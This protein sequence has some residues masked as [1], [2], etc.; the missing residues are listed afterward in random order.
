MKYLLKNHFIITFCLI[1]LVN[2]NVN[3]QTDSLECI[4]TKS[5]LKKLVTS[6]NRFEN[7]MNGT[8]NK[9][10]SKKIDSIMHYIFQT[11]HIVN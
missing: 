9:V 2:S 5:T 10:T 6:I 4:K 11:Q 7:T 1:A 8:D 3:A